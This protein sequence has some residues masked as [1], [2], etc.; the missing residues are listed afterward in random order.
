MNTI[1]VNTKKSFN[2]FQTSSEFYI[3]NKSSGKI[4]KIN[5]QFKASLTKTLP[6]IN[7]IQIKCILGVITILGHPFIIAVTKSNLVAKFIE[8][9][10]FEIEE[11]E[12]FGIDKSKLENELEEIKSRIN[13]I[14]KT[15]FYYSFSF[16]LTTKLSNQKT[17]KNLNNSK[18]SLR[19]EELNKYFF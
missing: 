10:I 16:D 4:L 12:I 2:F 8:K 6:E 5:K 9:E 7:S 11:I 17:L 19:Y 14:F 3:E 13:L 1:N 18:N 15:G